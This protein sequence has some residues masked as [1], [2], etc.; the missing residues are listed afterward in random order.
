MSVAKEPAASPP[1]TPHAA[2]F[3]VKA[4][5]QDALDCSLPCKSLVL[6]LAACF[7]LAF[8][9]TSLSP[10]TIWYQSHVVHRTSSSSTVF[11]FSGS[12]S[13][14]CFGSGSFE[15]VPYSAG[16]WAFNSGS[17]ANLNPNGQPIVDAI[18][19]ATSISEGVRRLQQG[20]VAAMALL[21]TSIALLVLFGGLVG[22]ALWTSDFVH[23][24]FSLLGAK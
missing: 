13:R 3:A 15:G 7:A 2:L 16:C 10:N 1:G 6:A 8:S 19:N 17:S 21:A 18:M 20:A 12:L 14:F 24:H 11:A 23:A 5:V 9:A 4:Q 22:Y